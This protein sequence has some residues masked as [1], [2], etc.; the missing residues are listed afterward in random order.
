MDTAH[1]GSI[2]LNRPQ[3]PERPFYQKP[4]KI[5]LFATG[6]LLMVGGLAAA[7]VLY[8]YLGPASASFLITIPA[9]AL[10][11]FCASTRQKTEEI[12]PLIFESN[13]EGN[14]LYVGSRNVPCKSEKM[15]EDLLNEVEYKAVKTVIICGDGQLKLNCVPGLLH[16]K[17]L[18]KIILVDA[19]IVHKPSNVDTLDEQLT[20][21]GWPS[22]LTHFVTQT[23]KSSLEQALAAELEEDR[24]AVF[25]V[26][27]V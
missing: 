26:E 8:S 2:R 19:V 16:F 5:A 24:K 15:V 21:A 25:Y 17:S 20:K 4:S 9:G 6:V 10:L 23:R 27:T 1:I 12:P 13:E 22:T 3:Q 14:I 18:S 7:G 11:C